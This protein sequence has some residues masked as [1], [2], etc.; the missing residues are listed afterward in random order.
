MKGLPFALGILWLGIL[1]SAALPVPHAEAQSYPWCASY[2]GGMGG[3]SNCGFTT[4]QQ[5]QATI[6]GMGGFCEPNTQ[7]QPP[8]GP[9]PRYGKRS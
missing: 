4:L 5:C 8:A 6:S 9:A 2:G 1:L 3:S 7:Y